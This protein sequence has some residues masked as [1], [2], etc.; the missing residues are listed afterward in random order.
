MLGDY[1]DS[2][3]NLFQD[4][5]KEE[6]QESLSMDHLSHLALKLLIDLLFYGGQGGSRRLWMVLID[7][8]SQ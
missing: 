4:R 2:F 1:L 8:S 5:M 3:C 7:R 6:E